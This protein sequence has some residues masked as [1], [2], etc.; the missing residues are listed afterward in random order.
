MVREVREWFVSGGGVAW[1][2]VGV[3]VS[4]RLWGEEEEGPVGRFF[5]RGLGSRKTHVP[6]NFGV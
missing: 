6:V 2:W 1:C 3:S 5:A 4:V